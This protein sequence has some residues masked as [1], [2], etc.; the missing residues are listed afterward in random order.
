MWNAA[1]RLSVDTK[2]TDKMW[3][4]ESFRFI[5]SGKLWMGPGT[6][7][8]PLEL[9]ALNR[10]RLVERVL[11]KSPGNAVIV[12]QGGNEVPFYDTDTTYN[13]FRQVS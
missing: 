10:R 3:I 4:D 2:R 9:F 6:L 12:L 8:I 11:P 1:V 5:F 7:E 13:V